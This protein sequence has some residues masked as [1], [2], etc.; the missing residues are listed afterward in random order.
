MN[1]VEGRFPD[2]VEF[3]RDMDVVLKGLRA[4]R[5]D[6]RAAHARNAEHGVY[7]PSSQALKRLM[8]EI[9]A[10]LFP[11]RLGPPELTTANENA[12]VGAMLETTLDQ[13]GAQ[14]ILELRLTHDANDEHTVALAADRIIAAFAASL[15]AIRRLLDTD[16]EAGYRKDPA[17]R[18][19]DEILLCYPSL[20][21]VIHHRIAH[22]L[23]EL[24]APIVA[25]TIA[26][27]AHRQTGIDIHPGAAI[28]RS[29][30]IDHGTGLVIGETA[31]VGDRVH[32]HQ[33]VTLGGDADNLNATAPATV[34]ARRHPKIG[35]DVVIFAGAAIIGP[36]TVGA[37][38]RIEGNIW[39]SQD[40]PPDSL[41]SAP[42][43]RITSHPDGIS[44]P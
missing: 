14:I 34:P 11:L 41:V 29:V 36:V 2:P 35:D 1:I 15:P 19:V 43:P 10:A 18:S 16:V 17:A 3:P 32:L 25:R 27:I 42:A 13:L 39:L 21:A 44:F 26:A 28:G 7:F 24:G 20:L 23:H 8:K 12:Y 31:L 33:G 37:R 38:S 4:A 6:W 40:V 9:C 22:R 30:F 5:S